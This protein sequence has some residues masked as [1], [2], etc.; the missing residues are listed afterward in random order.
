[1]NIIRQFK[2]EMDFK[3]QFITM[4][5]NYLESEDNYYSFDIFGDWRADI[6]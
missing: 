5:E 2:V 4:R 3:K 6:K 1:M